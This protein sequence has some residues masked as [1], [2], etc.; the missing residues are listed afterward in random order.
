[1]NYYDLRINEEN[2]VWKKYFTFGEYFLYRNKEVEFHLIYNIGNKVNNLKIQAINSQGVVLKENEF[3]KT[4]APNFDR[5][6][7][8]LFI[9]DSIL[10]EK[11][12][13][14][15]KGLEFT[16]IKIDGKFQNDYKLMNFTNVINCVDYINS[17]RAE[18]DFFSTLVL[19]R[20]K[21]P[22][23]LDGFFLS[24]WD[25]YGEFYCIVND[26]LKSQL[27]KIEK[28]SEFLIFDKIQVS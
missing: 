24:G 16:T 27:L 2:K 28:A 7:N 21:I 15:I 22:N 6:Q 10:D 18:F 11:L 4:T 8:I 17:V 12:F 5:I 14:D 25:E 19:D 26:K 23:N 9:K 13:E 3:T 1:M 20:T